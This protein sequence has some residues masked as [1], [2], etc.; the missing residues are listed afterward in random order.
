[1]VVGP[2]CLPQD[3]TPARKKGFLDCIKQCTQGH[4]E[5]DEKY[6][7]NL[8]LRLWTNCLDIANMIRTSFLLASTG[9]YDYR[10]SLLL[11]N[12]TH[13]LGTFTKSAAF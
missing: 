2:H 11:E 6:I 10:L 4:V 7:M 9:H 3:Y 1:V 8:S 13:D 12:A 5:V